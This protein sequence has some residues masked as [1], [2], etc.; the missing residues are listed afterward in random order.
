M[1]WAI[2]LHVLITGGSQGDGKATA[3][4]FAA[5]GWD[6][7]AAARKGDRINKVADQIQKFGQKA[8][9]IPTDVG[10]VEPVNTLVAQ[11]LDTLG[12]CS[13]CVNDGAKA[14]G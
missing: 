3:L 2:A 9:A 8:L 5:Q 1:V 6:V 11:S 14:A 10:N 12:Y 7:T 13:G 4:K